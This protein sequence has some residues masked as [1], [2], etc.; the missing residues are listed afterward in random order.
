MR[1][2]FKAL[3][4]ATALMPVATAASAQDA[5]RERSEGRRGD[6]ADRPERA[7]RPDR[8]GDPD[9]ATRRAVRQ[10][11]AQRLGGDQPRG[12]EWNRGAARTAPGPV[13]QA[14][15]SRFRPDPALVERRRE[16]RA[17]RDAQPGFRDY[18]RTT[19]DWNRQR[20]D[21]ND[22][23]RED[24]RDARDWN[25]R[26]DRNDGR[27]DDRRVAGD[28]NRG[29]GNDGWRNDGWRNDDRRNGQWRDDRRFDNRSAWNRTWRNDRRYD[30]GG[31]RAGNRGAYRLSR[32]YAPSGWGYG[33]RRFS[34]G[35]TLNQVLWGQNYWIDDPYS[36]R[37]P[38]AYGPYRW[39]RYY[40]DALLVDVRYGQVV[41]VVHDIFW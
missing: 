35:V 22:I 26:A 30:W 24:R 5:P 27:R 6:R 38:E 23:R 11:A 33:Y 18:G 32:Y 3:L 7:E 34:V 31:Y 39:V 12:G 1:F 40:N 2:L 8:T 19:G 15:G 29:N 37:L 28:W 21:R 13:A 41:D 4:A 14:E 25:G 36:Y 20:A 9:R 17:P 10:A 16:T